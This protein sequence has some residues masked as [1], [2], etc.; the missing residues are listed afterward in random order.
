MVQTAVWRRWRAIRDERSGFS[1]GFS[2]ST[3]ENAAERAGET[4]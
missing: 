4:T 1:T 2:T 3:C